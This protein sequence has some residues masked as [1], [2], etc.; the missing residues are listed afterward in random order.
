MTPLL[1]QLEKQSDSFDVLVDIT[2]SCLT[3]LQANVFNVT[4]E[5]LYPA[6]DSTILSLKSLCSILLS[7]A[8]P[9]PVKIISTMACS[10]IS[11]GLKLFFPSSEEEIQLLLNLL[12]NSVSSL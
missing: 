6:A 4:I 8:R 3:I 7:L 11:T 5:K 9:F 10:V 2:S 1:A 12:L